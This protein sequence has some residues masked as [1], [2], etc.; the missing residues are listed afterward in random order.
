MAGRSG[1]PLKDQ[2]SGN[3]SVSCLACIFVP[4]SFLPSFCP[5]FLLPPLCLPRKLH[6]PLC[7]G[8]TAHA[9]GHG[10]GEGGRGEGSNGLKDRQ[11]SYRSFMTAVVPPFKN[12]YFRQQGNAYTV[13][14]PCQE[15]RP[16]LVWR[17]FVRSFASSR[18]RR[19]KTSSSWP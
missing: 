7:C 1:P 11:I 10:D 4:T 19:R 8:C 14:N 16:N 15:R 9:G 18:P 12:V 17:P 2:S 3:A 6:Y 13:G 5:F